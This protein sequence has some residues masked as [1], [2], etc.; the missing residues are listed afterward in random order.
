MRAAGGSPI[1]SLTPGLTVVRTKDG[2]L[3]ANDSLSL[4]KALTPEQAAQV[5]K[6]LE[7]AFEGEVVKQV[8]QCH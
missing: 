7:D 3:W 6:A 4:P 2:I 8:T 5:Q 1:P